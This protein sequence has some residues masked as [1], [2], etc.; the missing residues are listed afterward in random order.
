MFFPLDDE[1]LGWAV[2]CAEGAEYTCRGI[3]ADMPSGFIERSSGEFRVHLAGS[4][5][6]EIPEGGLEHSDGW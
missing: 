4:L 5:S 6:E 1:C 3:E 2:F